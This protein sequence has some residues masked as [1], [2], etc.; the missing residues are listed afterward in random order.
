MYISCNVYLIIITL[1]TRL[2]KR[3][4]R[5]LNNGKLKFDVQDLHK[6]CEIMILKG[7]TTQFHER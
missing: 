7:I 3:L 4:E 6:S 1:L 5:G 2:A